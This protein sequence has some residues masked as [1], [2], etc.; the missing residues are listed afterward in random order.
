MRLDF[1]KIFKFITENDIEQ[2]WNAL[3]TKKLN[4]SLDN[5]LKSYRSFK[6]N[7]INASK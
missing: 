2:S 7:D 3:P 6:K 1:Q 4:L 5:L